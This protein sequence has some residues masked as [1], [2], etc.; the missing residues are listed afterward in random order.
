MP[1]RS[2]CYGTLF[3]QIAIGQAQHTDEGT[4]NHRP[5]RFCSVS[6]QESRILT[7]DDVVVHLVVDPDPAL[8]AVRVH[9]VVHVV[10]VRALDVSVHV[11]VVEKLGVGP[12]F[13]AGDRQRAR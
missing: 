6:L 9:A 3:F 4:A 11:H 1:Q 7:V 2:S 13:G 8:V 10:N 12:S 5:L